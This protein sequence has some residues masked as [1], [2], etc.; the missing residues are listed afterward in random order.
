MRK[1]DG[2]QKKTSGALLNQEG[3]DIRNIAAAIVFVKSPGYAPIFWEIDTDWGLADFPAVR[4]VADVCR[5]E[6]LFEIVAEAM[7]R[8][9]STCV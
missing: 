8:R 9:E 6:L 1:K 3:E 4:I 2:K 7:V 5:K